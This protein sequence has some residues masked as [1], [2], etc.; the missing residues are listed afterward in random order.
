MLK[1]FAAA[2]RF[3]TIIPLPFPV[4][5][6]ELEQLRHSAVVFPAVGLAL[7]GFAWLAARGA[8]PFLPPL[9]LAALGVTLLAVFSGGLHL[10]GWADS[11]DALFSPTHDR[12]KALAVMKDSRIGA[13]GAMAL[14]LLLLLK[15]ACLASLPADVL[16]LCLLLAPMAGRA[17]MVFPML[18]LP[19]ARE[20]GL[21][22]LFA[23]EHC[24]RLL[25]LACLWVG[26]GL[27]LAWGTRGFLVGFPLWLG[28][29][30][31]WTRFLKYRLGGATGDNY[32]AA[33]ELGETCLCLVAAILF[34]AAG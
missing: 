28:T 18:L 23:A 11:A 30:L 14:F 16:P 9:A 1:R 27:L 32:G 33:C 2:W 26:V 15:F 31:L 6:D 4:P 34:N 25:C 12:E 10:D 5:D 22:K 24:R 3:L 19:Y 7:G 20:K 29:A 13:H 17:A 8:L 21:G